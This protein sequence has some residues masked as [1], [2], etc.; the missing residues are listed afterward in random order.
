MKL[1]VLESLSQATL[2]ATNVCTSTPPGSK[3]TTVS[4]KLGRVGSLEDLATFEDDM[5]SLPTDKI[6]VL[7]LLDS[8]SVTS[9]SLKKINTRVRRKG[10]ELKDMAVRQ[11][12]RVMKGREADIERLRG[13]VLRQVGKLEQKLSEERI[14]TATE[15]YTFAL[16]LLNVFFLGFLMGNAPEYFHIAYSIQL[17]F[18]LPIRIYS[19]SRKEYH[20]YLAD[21]CYFVNFLCVVYIWLLPSSKRLFVACYAL[22]HGTLSFAVITWR[23]S[24][25]LHSIEKTT[26]TFIH[27]LP[28]VVFHTITH[29]IDENFK[30]QRFEG[31]R[32]LT[33]W[34]VIPGML[35]ATVAYFTWQILYHYFITIRRKDKI[36]AGRVTSFEYLRKAYA[37]TKLGMFVNGL[38]GFLPVVAFT[39]I[40]FGYQLGTMLLCPIW[41]H[42]ETL[43]ALFMTFIFMKAAYNGA[44]YYIDIFGKRFQKELLKLQAEVSEWQATTSGSSSPSL[45]PVTERSD[46]MPLTADVNTALELGAADAREMQSDT[47][48]PKSDQ[49]NT[50]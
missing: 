14:V 24:L 13:S 16:G 46:T 36:K 11:R 25:V 8:F 38:P 10:G 26:S 43:S 4:P 5:G 42:S 20:Y 17:C 19:Y 40:Q 47:N 41:Y 12:N 37:K 21:L 2:V 9:Q 27:I 3:L 29:R 23:N 45:R 49:P 7:D 44:T 48:L 18:L 1:V 31:A 33:R 22:T 28:P 39:F 35:C 30:R 15:K 6:S 34:E 50:Q 32:K